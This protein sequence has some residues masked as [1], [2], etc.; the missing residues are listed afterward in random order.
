MCR[1]IRKHGKIRVETT[2]D[3][4]TGVANL[5]AHIRFL[6]PYTCRG[7]QS[8]GVAGDGGLLLVQGQ[9]LYRQTAD[10]REGCEQACQDSGRRGRTSGGFLVLDTVARGF[11]AG[12]AH[13]S[14]ASRRTEHDDAH[15]ARR[16]IAE[17]TRYGC[18]G[19]CRRVQRSPMRKEHN[20]YSIL[21]VNYLT[22]R[23]K[24]GRF[25]R[26]VK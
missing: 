22:A 23:K 5:S 26:F 13:P 18:R 12:Y 1:K 3:I 16:Q 19:S 7:G 14:G 17:G 21:C 11:G 9:G 20:L 8:R 2:T 6:A 15:D 25:A 4:E 24:D 10:G